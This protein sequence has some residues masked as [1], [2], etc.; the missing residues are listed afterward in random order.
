MSRAVRAATHPIGYAVY[1]C[2]CSS[3]WSFDGPEKASKTSAV[4]SVAAMGTAPA[5]KILA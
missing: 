3:A 1:E 2:P 4:V 5:V